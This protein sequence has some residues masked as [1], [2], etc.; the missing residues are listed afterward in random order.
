MVAVEGWSLQPTKKKKP[1][2]RK[3]T[4]WKHNP[5]KRKNDDTLLGYSGWTALRGEQCDMTPESGN[6]GIR[7]EVIS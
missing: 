2:Q 1:Q 3:L 6:S 5:R 7:L 4:C